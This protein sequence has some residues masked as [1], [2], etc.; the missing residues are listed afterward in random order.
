[1]HDMEFVG[2]TAREKTS[3]TETEDDG[4]LFVRPVIRLSTVEAA[5]VLVAI[6]LLTFHRSIV[7]M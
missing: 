6:I 1:M 7:A 3:G 4:S 2:S 5:E